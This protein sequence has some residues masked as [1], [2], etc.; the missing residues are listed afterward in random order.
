MKTKAQE[1]LTISSCSC[2][3]T[4][5]HG[6]AGYFF[7]DEIISG[8]ASLVRMVAPEILIAIT[9]HRKMPLN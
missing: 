3:F 2:D 7:Y 6:K 4:L 9:Y 8:P 1:P 5:F